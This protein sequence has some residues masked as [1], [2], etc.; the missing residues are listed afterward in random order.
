MAKGNI[1]RS[2][3]FTLIELLVVLA[4]MVLLVA[5]IVPVVAKALESS[6]RAKCAANLSAIGKA[7]RGYTEENGEPPRTNYRSFNMPAYWPS[8]FGN[9][10]V[11]VTAF[12]GA[13]GYDS[14]KGSPPAGDTTNLASDENSRPYDNDVTAAFFMLLKTER[15]TSGSFV[16]PSAGDYYPDVYESKR[17][18]NHSGKPDHKQP[19]GNPVWRSNFTKK[20]NLSYSITIPYPSRAWDE[21]GVI[22][23]MDAGY[24]YDQRMKPQMALAADINP[25]DS[26]SPKKLSQL[27]LNDIG[28]TM[29]Q[30]NSRNHKQDGQNVLY[31]TGDVQWAKNP[32]CGGNGDNIY[33]RSAGSGKPAADQASD[34]VGPFGGNPPSNAFDNI[35]LPADT[36]LNSGTM[37]PY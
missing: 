26:G 24:R 31:V 22:S 12:S 25:G 29:R 1:V 9:N 36:G 34:T 13:R 17:V 23:A 27:T 37:M 10:Q 5:I 14:Y 6:R 18:R 15:L 3:G 35:L 21:S 33:T 20:N 28:S 30:G 11:V 19:D 4:V 8:Y 2:R 16:C 7:W 32:F